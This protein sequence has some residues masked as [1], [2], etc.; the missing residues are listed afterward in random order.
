MLGVEN[1][2]VQ[3][4][5]PLAARGRQAEIFHSFLDMRRD[6]GPIKSGKLLDQVGGGSV[7]ELPIAADFLELVK[8]R[9]G[10]SR[11]QGVAE[12]SDQIGSLNQPLL[13][14][15]LIRVWVPVW[16][17]A[18]EFDRRRDAGGVEGC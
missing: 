11:I 3:I 15:R 9:V 8:Q 14:I 16:R 10:L 4:G 7:A 18:G 2:I 1:V 5:D 13:E 17:E 6:G 12:L